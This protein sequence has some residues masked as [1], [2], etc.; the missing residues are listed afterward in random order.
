MCFIYIT[1]CFQYLRQL[2]YISTEPSKGL[3]KA[4]KNE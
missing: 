3:A 1:A 2:L 4:S